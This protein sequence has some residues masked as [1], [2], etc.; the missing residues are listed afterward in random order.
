M[1]QHKT[2]AEYLYLRFKQGCFWR[3]QNG[4]EFFGA[5]EEEKNPPHC[6]I[7]DQICLQTRDSKLFCT[8]QWSQLPLNNRIKPFTSQFPHMS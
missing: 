4:L 7:S 8:R 1:Y 2:E 6:E 5:K 3:V